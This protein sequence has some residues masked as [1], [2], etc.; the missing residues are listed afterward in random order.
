M[1]D[2]FRSAPRWTHRSFPQRMVLGDGALA[3][4][5]DEVKGVGIR[6]AL[7]VT[8]SRRATSEMG[9]RLVRL[10]GRTLA[11][12]FDRV[13]S[14]V[15]IPLVRDASA[16]ADEVNADGIVSFGGGSCADLGKAVAF[17]AEQRQGTPG[18]EILDRPVLPHVA[19]PTTWSGAELTAGFGMTDPATRRKQ[20]AG[21]PTC[22][23]VVVI[24]DPALALGLD[25][26]V[27]AGSGMN[28]LAHGV[29]CA[30]STSRTAE[31]EAIALACISRTVD[32]L[33]AVVDDPSDPVAVARMMEASALGGR[34]LQ[35]ATMGVHHGL[36]QLLGG[37]AGVAHGMANGI[38]LEHCVAFNSGD[39][40][41]AP[42]LHRI[43]QALGDP[44]DAAGAVRRLRERIGSAGAPV[45]CGGDGGGR[46]R[47]R[48]DGPGPSDRPRE[49]PSGLRG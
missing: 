37:R 19:I 18:T 23:P 44:D 47:R 9:E 5:A 7:L 14:H 39:P 46:R 41:L 10:L 43:G 12:T 29:E 24:Y 15:P 45:R 32:A 4:I 8:T 30:W 2:L 48:P 31:A 17:F 16:L 11:A 36:S 1:D 22:A 35:N 34:A 6:R 33:P 3:G 40:L 20:G 27:S 13:E 25:P 21:A 28:C 49:P 42:V 26:I 38:L